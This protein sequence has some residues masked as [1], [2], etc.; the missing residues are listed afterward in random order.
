MRGD[1]TA[2]SL[3]ELLARL[4]PTIVND[5]AANEREAGMRELEGRITRRDRLETEAVPLDPSAHKAIVEGGARLASTPSLEAVKRWL[6]ASNAKP[7]LVISGGT[8]CGKSVSAA[9]AVAHSPTGGRW[10]TAA[11]VCRVF[12][13]QYGD[14]LSDQAVM[15]GT[16]LLVI[17]DIGTE[18][19]GDRM[20]AA[21]VELLEY[22]RTRRTLVTTNLDK[23]AFA[24]RYP[25]ERLISRMRAY[26]SWVNDKGSDMRKAHV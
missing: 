4:E 8:G 3:R 12:G 24:A 19:H 15:R 18:L 1:D 17:D 23:R 25:D 22:R 14:L 11:A 26:S 13:A 7:L 9:Y 6:G 20:G 16:G 5:S 10:R 2:S 21:L